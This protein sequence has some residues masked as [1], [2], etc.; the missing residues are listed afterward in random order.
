MD[1]KTQKDI[2]SEW[3][4]TLTPECR[5]ALN[6]LFVKHGK[7]ETPQ[8]KLNALITE[9]GDCSV[10]SSS[11]WRRTQEEIDETKLR[12]MSLEYLECLGLYSPETI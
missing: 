3:E 5:N 12:V 10:S 1:D 7:C 6:E 11:D 9:I 2:H 4:S 8:Q